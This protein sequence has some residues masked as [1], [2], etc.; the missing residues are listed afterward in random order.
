[1]KTLQELYSEI[2]ASEELKAAFTEAAKS[3]KATEFLKAQGCEATAEELAAFLKNQ[4]TGEI[5]DEELDSVA[6]GCN[7]A[8]EFEAIFSTISV[9]VVCIAMALDSTSEAY[10]GRMKEGVD[11]RICK[12]S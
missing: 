1:M 10:A 7:D 12:S 11:G 8:T 3:G 9:G 2:I 4:S 5:S 6:G